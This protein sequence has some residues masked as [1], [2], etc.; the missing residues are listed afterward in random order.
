MS[1]FE[2]LY[3]MQMGPVLE[4]AVGSFRLLPP[5]D[6]YVPPYKDPWRFWWCFHLPHEISFFEIVVNFDRRG[7]YES[8]SVRNE[9]SEVIFP[10]PNILFTIRC[11]E[12]EI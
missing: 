1:D 3:K 6:S 12:I 2:G 8:C 7:G 9:P 5:T 4:R 10:N 11:I